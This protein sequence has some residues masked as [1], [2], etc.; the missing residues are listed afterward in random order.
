MTEYRLAAD[1]QSGA[2][3]FV[4]MIML[5]ILGLLG[6]SGMQSIVLQEHMATNTYDRSIG[7]QAAEA[8]LRV[9]EEIAQAQSDANNAGFP[10]S[11][12]C[13]ASG[14]V[15]GLCGKAANTCVPRW[16]QADFGGWVNAVALESKLGGLAITPQYFIEIIGDRDLSC[17]YEKMPGEPVAK[18]CSRYRITA[19]SDGGADRAVVMLQ[20]VYAARP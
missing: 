19:R 12:A 9:G 13:D 11:T 10:A 16:E 4:A 18:D 20:S 5:M 3:L 1:S 7:F 17:D 8:A 6:V 15:N 14:C 2:T